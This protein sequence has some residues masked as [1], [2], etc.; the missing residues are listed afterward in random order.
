MKF[1]IGRLWRLPS[2]DRPMDLGA[3]PALTG[4]AA[5]PFLG[6]WG[7]IPCWRK[8]PVR[9]WSGTTVVPVVIRSV[10]TLKDG[11]AQAVAEA[12]YVSKPVVIYYP[13]SA[14]TLA[15]RDR[16]YRRHCPLPTPMAVDRESPSLSGRMKLLMVMVIGE[17]CHAENYS[18]GN[19]CSDNISSAKDGK[20]L[21]S[22]NL[23]PDFPW[24]LVKYLFDIDGTVT[25]GNEWWNKLGVAKV[26]CNDLATTAAKI[27]MVT[28]TVVCPDQ[29]W[30][31][32]ITG[33]AYC[34][35]RRHHYECKSNFSGLLFAYIQPP[36][37]PRQRP[38]S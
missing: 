13:G 4:G 34:Q 6:R 35:G 17:T 5:L 7:A 37:H 1:N 22:R 14:L 11:Q 36:L 8:M 32:V 9:R 27:I 20:N 38:Q 33:G 30:L 23:T 15:G 12:K 24:D 16:W 26:A 29:L 31:P 19:S 21:T 3:L 25:S 18:G 2:R 10:A 28:G